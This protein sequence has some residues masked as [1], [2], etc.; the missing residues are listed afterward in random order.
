MRQLVRDRRH[1]ELRRHDARL[2]QHRFE[3][4]TQRAAVLLLGTQLER[5]LGVLD[6]LTL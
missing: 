3:V 6:Q 2:R 4:P 1:V 5:R